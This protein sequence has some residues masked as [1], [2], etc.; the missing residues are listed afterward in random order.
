MH[1][2]GVEEFL[3]R[4]R[5]KF[6][7]ALRDILEP[8]QPD[9]MEVG[10]L[11]PVGQIAKQ[12]KVSPLRLREVS[13]EL[14]ISDERL[15]GVVEFNPNVQQLGLKVLLGGG[16][17]KRDDWQKPVLGKTKFQRLIRELNLGTPWKQL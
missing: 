16:V 12:Y 17:I 1:Q 6:L 15:K 14:G 2:P 13:A 5:E 11:E 8:W 3:S 10:K 4:D 9:S 7:F